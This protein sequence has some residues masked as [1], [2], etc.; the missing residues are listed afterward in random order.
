MEKVKKTFRLS[1]GAASRLRELSEADGTTETQVLEAAL[2]SYR[3]DGKGT[4]GQGREAG[5]SDALIAALEGNVADLRNQVAM[6]TEQLAVK[7]GQIE[8]A[9]RHIDQ[10][11]ALH[12]ATD[13]ANAKMLADGTK[14]EDAA[15][16]GGHG[17]WS[18]L[19]SR[20]R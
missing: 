18:R 15:G 13:A 3:Q 10:A 20:N 8:A 6:L 16:N 1:E 4:G 17:F 5:G 11:Q 2:L 19:F 9:N 14:D 12:A 7:D